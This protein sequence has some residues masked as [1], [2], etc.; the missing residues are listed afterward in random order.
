M[1][2]QSLAHYYEMLPR[3]AVAPPGYNTVGV[4]FA[5]NI[6]AAGELLDVFPLFNQEQ[7]GRKMVDVPRRM[8]VPEQVKRSSGVN[9]NFLCDNGVYVLGMT[10]KDSSDPDYAIKRFMAFCNFN[11]KLLDLA[12]CTT[13]RAVSAFLDRHEPVHALEHPAIVAYAEG[14]KK[15][16]NLVF[17]FRGDFA[18]DDLKI[19]HV[20]GSY[21]QGQDAILG[22]CLV[23]GEIAPIARLHPSLKRIK[24]AQSSGA[25]LV[26]F[27][28][29]AYESYGHSQGL[30]APV[31]ELATFAYTTALNY[32]LSPENPNRPILLGDTTVVY[33]AES[34]KPGYPAAFASIFGTSYGETQPGK[35]E[36]ER[37]N[38]EDRLG[39]I[40]PRVQR[41]Q[42]I[43]PS[44]LTDGLDKHVRFYVLGLAPNAS[45]VA[46]RFFVMEPFGTIIE[47]IM[48]HY[49]DMKIVKEFDDQPDYI[50]LY[51]ILA[52]TVS[53]KARDQE[54]T[55][56]LSSSMMRAIL[57]DLP[58]PAALYYAIINRL[59]ADMDDAESHIQKVNY[60]R[61]GIIK[62]YLIRKYRR[63]PQHPIQ[64]VLAMSLNEQSTYAPYVLGRLFA[65]LE[66]VQQEAIGD[67][68]ASVK[69]RYFTSACASPASAFPVLLR[70][71]QHHISKAQYGYARDRRIEEIL[72]LLDIEQNPIP[73]H[74]ALDDQGVFV[75][76]YYHERKDLW[77]SKS[78]KPAEAIATDN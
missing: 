35:N 78:K 59:R 9:P 42:P 69:D 32:L 21:K 40:A 29:P 58:Y 43:D 34:D 2:L 67:V 25:T 1:I 57:S 71:S 46:V 31:S 19:R 49:A 61:A 73:S 76:G 16:G 72:N 17:M 51:R 11:K 62:A 41:A 33:W 4:T 13:A 20:W 53:R 7:R 74:L 75:L 3:S 28:S 56:L 45:R 48:H 14:L 36:Q 23:T 63:Q 26:G 65:V 27:N 60:V 24:G 22:Q 77:T 30:N 18:H 6:S 52:E 64:E 5:L 15:G 68:N 70:L 44:K 8:V 39:K 47:R 12:D 50:P 38:A 10:D 37:S 54:P 66:K 55:P